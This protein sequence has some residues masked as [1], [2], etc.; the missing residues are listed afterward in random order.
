MMKK[1]RVKD[2]MEG[3]RKR[4]PQNRIDGERKKE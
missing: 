4:E 2:K 3:A 1:E